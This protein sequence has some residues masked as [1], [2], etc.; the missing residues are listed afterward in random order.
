MTDSQPSTDY[1]GIT[2]I[3][4]LLLLL[5]YAGYLA[6]KS[7]DFDVLNK[8][9]SQ[10]LILPPPATSSAEIITDAVVSPTPTPNLSPKSP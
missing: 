9:E 10:P 8:L 4:I 2:L 1:I 7:I 6:H 5:A 3:S